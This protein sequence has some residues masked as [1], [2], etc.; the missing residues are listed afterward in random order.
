MLLVLM[1]LMELLVREA[2]QV[3]LAHRVIVLLELQ[4][5]KA[6]RVTVL[7]VLQ[8]LEAQQVIQVLLDL[9]VPTELLVREAQ[10]VPLAHKVIV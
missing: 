4:A 3:P 1:E 10:Q 5:H 7:L 2:Q 8:V 6:H 9:M